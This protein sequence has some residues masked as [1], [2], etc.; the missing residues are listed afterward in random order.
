MVIGAFNEK[1]RR[2]KKSRNTDGFVFFLCSHQRKSHENSFVY[3]IFIG[4][5][6]LIM[7]HADRL[8][9]RSRSF[10]KRRSEQQKKV[11]HQISSSSSVS[12]T[13]RKEEESSKNSS[14]IFKQEARPLGTCVRKCAR[15]RQLKHILLAECT[16]CFRMIDVDL[17]DCKCQLL[18]NRNVTEQFYCS[19]CNSQLT[20]DGYVIC[21]NRTCQTILSAL[22]KIENNQQIEGNSLSS[23]SL[24]NI[25][26]PKPAHRTV[27]IQVNT[28][29]RSSSLQGHLS[30]QIDNENKESSS[31]SSY[32]KVD[33]VQTL[34]T[35]SGTSNT[36][37]LSTDTGGDG[38]F[39]DIAKNIRVGFNSNQPTKLVLQSE[40]E[41]L[42]S[43]SPHVCIHS[44]AITMKLSL[45]LL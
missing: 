29:N 21:A 17:K 38:S 37:D 23:T 36:S 24:T 20:L 41:S 11:E 13:E 10:R 43:S 30:T 40:D 4:I 39:I 45:S 26:Y 28:L 15:C 42:Q 32:S 18:T 31:S 1:Y 34:I 6:I 44:K 8:E 27:A 12:A 2:D 3:R 35:S 19:I 25:C 16:V 14:T 22:I 9:H 5:E 7:N 33:L